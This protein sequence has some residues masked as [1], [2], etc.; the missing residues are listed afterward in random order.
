MIV[1]EERWGR[2]C[3]RS[4]MRRQ[5]EIICIRTEKR[6]LATLLPW[7][8][9]DKSLRRVDAARAPER[10]TAF[11]GWISAQ[12]RTHEHARRGQVAAPQQFSPASIRS[13]TKGLVKTCPI[14]A[15]T[16]Q[17]TRTVPQVVRMLWAGYR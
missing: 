13:G 17:C 1:R 7:C 11:N 10:E 4:A 16:M 15:I 2:Q 12:K 5:S 9:A 3:I 8:E 14:P 6:Q